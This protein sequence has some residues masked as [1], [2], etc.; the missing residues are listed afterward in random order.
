MNEP[1]LIDCKDMIDLRRAGEDVPERSRDLAHRFGLVVS[2]ATACRD[3]GPRLVPLPCPCN[4]GSGSCDGPVT[5][6]R[7]GEE[8]AWSCGGCGST[9][10]VCAWKKSPW[11]LG[12]LVAARKGRPRR[13]ALLSPVEFAALDGLA[14][15]EEGGELALRGATVEGEEILLAAVTDDLA[16]LAMAAEAAMGGA[17]PCEAAAL[18][19]AAE[20][21][22]AARA[23]RSGN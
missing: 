4:D 11:D 20:K 5:V 21:L 9:G 8:I 10:R 7:E 19:S 3:A 23:G 14:M 1:W 12:P 22:L 13:R 2:A 18:G 6:G 16:E 15:I 17:C